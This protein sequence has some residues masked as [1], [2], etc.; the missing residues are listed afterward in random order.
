[1]LSVN[2]CKRPFFWYMVPCEE[3]GSIEDAVWVD[4]NFLT[5][6]GRYVHVHELCGP[7]G[8]GELIWKLPQFA[9]Q[10]VVYY[11]WSDDGTSAA[12]IYPR[13]CTG[14]YFHV[15]DPGRIRLHERAKGPRPP[16]SDEE[17][18]RRF[19]RAGLIAALACVK[20]LPGEQFCFVSRRGIATD[21]ED[22]ITAALSVSGD[23]LLVMGC[24][25]VHEFCTRG[26]YE[27][28]IV[29]DAEDSQQHEAGPRMCE[30]VCASAVTEGVLELGYLPSEMVK[31]LEPVGYKRP[32]SPDKRR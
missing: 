10:G 25:L 15:P 9:R 26:P 8:Y 3:V 17:H 28:C 27:R 31:Y 18:R 2:T 13:E 6:V 21:A 16:V 20:S 24:N 30:A 14:G 12:W 29:P 32:R 1:M 4:P 11:A 19:L 22:E 5:S 7:N 23:P